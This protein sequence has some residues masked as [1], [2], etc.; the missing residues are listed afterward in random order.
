MEKHSEFKQAVKTNLTAGPESCVWNGVLDVMKV[1]SCCKSGITLTD[2][3]GFAVL[4]PHTRGNN[5][6][7]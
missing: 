4:S 5:K 6:L 7:Q 1:S 2:Y 3:S